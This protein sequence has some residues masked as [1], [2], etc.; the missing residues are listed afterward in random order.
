MIADIKCLKHVDVENGY[1][2][3]GV[4]ED[5]LWKLPIYSLDELIEKA[6]GMK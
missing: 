2:V 4:D 6:E 3:I 1:L 5:S